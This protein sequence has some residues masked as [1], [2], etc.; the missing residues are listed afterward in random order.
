MGPRGRLD[1]GVVIV[2][3]LLVAKVFRV[4]VVIASVRGVIGSIPVTCKYEVLE[5]I[6]V[7]NSVDVG[8]D[9]VP[10]GGVVL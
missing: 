5:G 2:E 4:A 9:A 6:V 10:F 7:D 8:V 1:E 3:Q